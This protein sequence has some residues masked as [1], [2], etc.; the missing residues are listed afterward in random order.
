[1]CHTCLQGSFESPSTRVSIETLGA[2][3]LLLGF[4]SEAPAVLPKHVLKVLDVP[5]P[6]RPPIW[7]LNT[8]GICVSTK[9]LQCT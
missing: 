9:H 7:T 2:D 3:S 6:R 1:M 8:T 4:L 5:K